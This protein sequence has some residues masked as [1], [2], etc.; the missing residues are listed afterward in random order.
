MMEDLYMEGEMGEQIVFVTPLSHKM[1]R[2]AM[3]HGM[4]GPDGYFVCSS[5]K[6]R[7]D[8]GFEILAK[9]ATL[10]AAEIIFRALI[11]SRRNLTA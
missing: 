1:Y 5:L 7:P 10:E 9:A 6:S 4:G 11:G 2:E 3:G 8:A